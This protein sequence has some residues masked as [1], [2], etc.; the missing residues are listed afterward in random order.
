MPFELCLAD[1]VDGTSEI[2]TRQDVFQLQKA[3]CPSGEDKK[4]H[5]FVAFL[6]QNQLGNVLILS[7]PNGPGERLDVRPDIKTIHIEFDA[8]ALVNTLNE[9]Q[10][11]I[12]VEMIIEVF[13]RRDNAPKYVGRFSGQ[14][15]FDV[16]RHP[17]P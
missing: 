14:Y 10:N 9:F 7:L 2:E 3:A 15:F 1:T 17:S 13:T 11:F 4:R 16:E 6:E 5:T 12:D 8:G